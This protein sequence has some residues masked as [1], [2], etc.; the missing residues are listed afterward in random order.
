MTD[1]KNNLV[2]F[3]DQSQISKQDLEI[4]FRV[5]EKVIAVQSLVADQNEEVINL[6]ENIE[7]KQVKTLE[8]NRSINEKLEKIIKQN[9]DVSRDIFKMNIT[10][11]V[12]ILAIVAQVIS[13]FVKH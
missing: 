3:T 8:A 5:N 2:P 13:I 11:A 9:E 10:F 12:G 4:I 1:S 7:D 6:L